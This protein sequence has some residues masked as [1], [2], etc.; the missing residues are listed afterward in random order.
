MPSATVGS[1]EKNWSQIGIG[2]AIVQFF[3]HLQVRPARRPRLYFTEKG[4]R[5]ATAMMADKRFASPQRF[6][7]IRVELGID[8]TPD[9]AGQRSCAPTQ[10]ITGS[11]VSL[12]GAHDR[13]VIPGDEGPQSGA[14]AGSRAYPGGRPGS[15]GRGGDTD[16]RTG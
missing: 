5:H 7:H 10:V 13:H 16:R 14:F 9:A 6:A 11:A 8:F 2:F 3:E 1:V 12:E 4:C 15:A